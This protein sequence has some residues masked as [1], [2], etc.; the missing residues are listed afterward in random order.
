M[1]TVD[2]KI[3]K[4]TTPN[5]HQALMLTIPKEWVNQMG[6]TPEKRDVTLSFDGDIITV[7]SP[8]LSGIKKVPLASNNRI[9][10]FAVKWLEL[11]KNHENISYS[12][13]TGHLFLG[14][15]LS[16]LGFFMD[17]Y[18][19]IQK[20][21]PDV[22]TASLAGLKSVIDKV[23]IIP[24]GN[25]IFSKWR[26]FSHW[27]TGEMDEDDYQWFILA[28]TRLVEI[29]GPKNIDEYFDK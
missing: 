18:E 11:F 2:S 20:E 6:I 1:D 8:A 16:D 7:Q 23:E 15:E 9:Y 25:A 10:S 13:F 29:S 3:F 4:G 28:F 17:I 26:Y 22:K 24:L 27:E 5:G 21:F 12:L 14:R 19:A